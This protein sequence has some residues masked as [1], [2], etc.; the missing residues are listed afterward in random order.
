MSC[1][2]FLEKDEKGRSVMECLGVSYPC[3]PHASSDKAGDSDFCGGGCHLS[4]VPLLDWRQPWTA[5]GR[6]QA[7]Q[8]ACSPSPAAVGKH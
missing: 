6:A 3:V 8:G 7:L 2:I 4:L 5:T 1:C